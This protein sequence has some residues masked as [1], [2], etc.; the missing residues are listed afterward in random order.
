MGRL[1]IANAD[2]TPSLESTDSVN[3]P[4]MTA[5]EVAAYLRLPVKKVYEV[6]GKLAL[7]VGERRL[8]WRRDDVDQW[9]NHHRRTR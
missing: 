1:S 7:S 8:R 6:V 9:L 4:L 5:V 2:P 3:G